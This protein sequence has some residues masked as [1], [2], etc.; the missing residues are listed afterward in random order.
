MKKIYLII[1]LTGSVLYGCTDKFDDYNT[2]EKNPETVTG[3]SLFSN[4]QKE[5]CDQITSTNVNQNIW[6][7]W[8]QYWTETTYTDEANY[9]IISRNIPQNVFRYYYRTTLMDLY[10][11]D[12][13]I[14][15]TGAAFG[16]DEAVYKNKLYIID[17]LEVYSYQRLVDIFG[18]V[19]YTEALDIDNNIYPA[20]D[21]GSDI[22][23]DLLDRLNADIAGL[24]PTQDSFGS[25][26]DLYYSGDVSKWIKFANTLKIKLGISIADYDATMA[27]EAVESGVN[28]CFASNDDDCLMTYLQASP[29]YNPLYADLV[30]TGRHDFV[31]ANTL[32]D[33]MNDLNDPR[34]AAYFSN[35]VTFPYQTDDDGNKLD[36]TLTTGNGKLLLYTD[37]DGNDSLVYK[38][39]PFTLS[40]SD[41]HDKTVKIYSGGKYGYSSP[42]AQYS[43]IA[44]AIQEPDF[45]GILMTYSEVQF[46]LAEAAARGYDVPQTTEEYY[47]EGIRASFDFWGVSGADD[48][49]SNPDVAYTTAEGTWKQKIGTQSWL[50][51]YT[52][53][54]VGYTTWRRLD[55][56]ILNIAKSIKTYDEIPVRFTFPVNEQTLN[57]TNYDAAAEAIGGDELTTK[58]FWDKY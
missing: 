3:E 25:A 43:H 39:T 17:I 57:K 19:P 20:Y 23:A 29:N 58:I 12:S 5:L 18:M 49:V 13:I 46:Y 4:A 56:P 16:E 33:V 22:Y 50:A 37:V 32:T 30:A 36:T 11:A 26:E 31:I 47:N 54:L 41:A 55:Y 8:A 34:M 27:K 48:Y 45:N 7:L 42:F 24:D 51:S 35:P 10:Q 15:A 21:K 44:D 40:P 28:G 2:D 52:R 9:N 1:L 6:K 38:T 53:G 14:N